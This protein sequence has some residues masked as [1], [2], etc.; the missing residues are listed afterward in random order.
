MTV[1]T[2]IPRSGTSLVMQMLAAGGLPV[3]HDDARAED[4]D[5]PRGYYE[6]AAVKA[7]RRDTGWLAAAPGHA[8]KVVHALLP[9]LPADRPYRVISVHRAIDEVLAS[10]RAMLR[11]KGEPRTAP[12]EE[13]RMGAIQLQQLEAA[14]RWVDAVPGAALLRVR[15]AE[16]LRDPAGASQRIAAFV[17][18]ALDLAAMA[19]AVDPSLHRQ[20]LARGVL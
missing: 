15:H 6:L 1:V 10:Q 11:R 13:A 12:A 7:S 8:V 5:N 19:A 18:G 2:G 14:E 4:P 16:L 9:E 20:R 17:G 3:L